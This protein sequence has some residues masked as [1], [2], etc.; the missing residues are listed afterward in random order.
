MRSDLVQAHVLQ[1]VRDRVAQLR[2]RSQRK[3]HDAKRHAEALCGH[4]AHQLASAGDLKRCLL[5]LFSNLIQGSAR[6][7]AQRA[8]NNAGARDSDGYDAIWLLNAVE[9]TSHERI[10]A[11]GVGKDDELCTSNCRVILGQLGRFFNNLAH[12]CHSIHIDT[13]ARRCNIDRRAHHVGSR[14]SFRN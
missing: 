2:G 1:D 14:Q 9:G 7:V 6:K 8:V 13:C 4:V 11:H 12:L 10:I 5:D 3:V